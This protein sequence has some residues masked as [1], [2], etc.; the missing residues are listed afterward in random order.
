M[1]FQILCLTAGNLLAPFKVQFAQKIV[2]DTFIIRA[3][4]ARFS[5]FEIL[6][7]WGSPGGDKGTPLF[8]LRYN[9]YRN[10]K[11]LNQKSG[12]ARD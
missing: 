8:Q 3:S 12:N 7:I 6:G 11:D 4:D 2:V 9:C 10:I 5:F 1:M